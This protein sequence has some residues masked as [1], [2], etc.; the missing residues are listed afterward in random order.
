MDDLSSA[1]TWEANYRFQADPDGALQVLAADEVLNRNAGGTL[2]GFGTY[3]GLRE[4]IAAVLAANAN[5]LSNTQSPDLAFLTNPTSAIQ[6]SQNIL[7][8]QSAEVQAL[9]DQY[10]NP[11]TR[12]EATQVIEVGLTPLIQSS[13]GAPPS[14]SA[15]K[16]IA[17]TDQQFA[18]TISQPDDQFDQWLSQVKASAGGLSIVQ[19]AVATIQ[20]QR[21][22]LQTFETQDAMLSAGMTLLQGNSI[23][24]GQSVVDPVTGQSF[25]VTQLPQGFQLSTTPSS[26]GAGSIMPNNRITLTFGQ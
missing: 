22:Y 23:Q 19:P 14:V 6:A 13:L 4:N 21:N 1:A 5:A 9:L 2:G 25:F 8:G 16:W 11:A 7:S 17:Q 12:E 3:A 24:T 18:T 10:S 15:L 20:D 26:P